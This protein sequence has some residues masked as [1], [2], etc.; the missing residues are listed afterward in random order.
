MALADNSGGNSFD[1]LTVRGRGVLRII[2]YSSIIGFTGLSVFSIVGFFTVFFLASGFGFSGVLSSTGSVLNDV[3]AV[4]ERR[5]VPEMNT[6][7]HKNHDK[8]IRNVTYSP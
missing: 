4:L 5:N 3:G 1:N 6:L 8:M 2:L 7:D